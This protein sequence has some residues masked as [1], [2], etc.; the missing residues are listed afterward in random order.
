MVKARRI[1]PAFFFLLANFTEVFQLD[2]AEHFDLFAI[3]RSVEEIDLVQSLEARVID[4]FPDNF[5][6]PR[7][8]KRLRL[9]AHE[10]PRKVIADDSVSVCQPLASGGQSQRVAWHF[11]LA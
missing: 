6:V 5:F 10:G 2:S 3:S 1:T 9:F 4:K 8:F 11:V 7:H